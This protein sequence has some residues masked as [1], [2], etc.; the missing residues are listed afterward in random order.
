MKH[1]AR[2][3]VVQRLQA[4]PPVQ[5]GRI[6]RAIER[7]RARSP[8]P[9]GV[10]TGGESTDV[11]LILGQLAPWGEVG[12]GIETNGDVQA[13]ATTTVDPARGGGRGGRGLQGGRRGPR[14][15]GGRGDLAIGLPNLGI[16]SQNVGA[17]GGDSEHGLPILLD[18][19]VGGGVLDLGGAQRG[20]TVGRG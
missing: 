20:E 4:R 19:E 9:H 5:Y 6:S 15:R 8:L 16:G 7:A 17:V 12:V 13:I 2:R 11:P 3:A 18:S 10:Q 14:G 1:D